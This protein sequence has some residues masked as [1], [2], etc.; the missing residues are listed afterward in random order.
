MART[1]QT[2]RKSPGGK[3]PRKQLA[4]KAATKS[5]PATGGVKKPHRFRPG[6]IALREIRKYQKSTKLLIRK[7]PFQRLVREIA[8]DFKTDLRFQSSIVAAL[9]EVVEAYLV[10]TVIFHVDVFQLFTVAYCCLTCVD[11]AASFGISYSSVDA[12]HKPFI[13]KKLHSEVATMAC[14]SP[15]SLVLM[16][17][18][19]LHEN[20]MRSSTLLSLAH[21]ELS[22]VF[23]EKV[24]LLA[25]G[26]GK[27]LC[28][29]SKAQKKG[30]ERSNKKL[31]VEE[32]MEEDKSDQEV[33]GESSEKTPAKMSSEK[34]GDPGSSPRGMNHSM[35][36][37]SGKYK[38]HKCSKLAGSGGR[39][40][41]EMGT[42]KFTTLD[43]INHVQDSNKESG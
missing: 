14:L 42:V 30:D 8:Q 31:V 19:I 32:K 34:G 23:Y 43:G 26:G 7:L 41:V 9:Q 40:M 24:L 29:D 18:L 20:I 36:S 17:N 5:A 12:F 37:L 35:K 11:C 38:E 22:T 4:T 13:L 15:L 16:P 25:W 28:D 39:I 21:S 33:S 2:A 27:G 1:K 10:D 3:V 6:T